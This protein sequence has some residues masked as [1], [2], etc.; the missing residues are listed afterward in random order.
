MD[1]KNNTLQTVHVKRDGRTFR[2]GNATSIE[3]L[4]ELLTKITKP[5]AL[6]LATDATKHSDEQILDAAMKIVPMGLTYLCAWGPDCNR[7]HDIFDRII[8]SLEEMAESPFQK[9]IMTTWHDDEPLSEAVWFLQF[10]AWPA[11]AQKPTDFDCIGISV[12]N[13]LWCNKIK[14]A[15]IAN[16]SH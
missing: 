8:V 5:F 3:E 2:V 15:F 4:P 9:L 11:E 12:S 1:L 13:S 6:L 7:V 16:S 10:C 14:E